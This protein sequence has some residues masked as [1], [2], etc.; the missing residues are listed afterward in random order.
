[1]TNWKIY[2]SMGLI[3]TLSV[4]GWW[5]FKNWKDEIRK[6]IFNEF[7]VDLVEEKNKELNQT[8]KKLEEQVKI[9][10]NIQEQQKKMSEDI[11][12]KSDEILRRIKNK[13]DGKPS[14]L[15]RETM[16]AIYEQQEHDVK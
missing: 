8:V 7:F 2:I 10:Q 6:S 11:S 9:Q 15:L 1:M 13:P 5:I 3:V 12:R 16:S 4:V 14:P